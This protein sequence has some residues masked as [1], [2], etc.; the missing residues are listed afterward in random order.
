MEASNIK[1]AST[2]LLDGSAKEYH[3][4]HFTCLLKEF[5]AV[6]VKTLVL[7][8]RLQDRNNAKPN[9]VGYVT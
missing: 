6:C 8:C 9:Y 4:S 2:L 5:K 7:H 3:A 1:C